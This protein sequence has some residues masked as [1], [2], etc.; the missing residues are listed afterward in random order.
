[1]AP[2]LISFKSLLTCYPP[3]PLFKIASLL[4][5]PKFLM[6]LS[7]FIFY[8]WL[9]S[10][11]ETLSVFCLWFVS[12]EFTLAQGRP[13]ICLLLAVSPALSIEHSTQ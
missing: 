2:S 13:H 9:F 8:Q 10:P 5:H 6:P 1:M 11:S 7:C 3:D 4:L 12:R